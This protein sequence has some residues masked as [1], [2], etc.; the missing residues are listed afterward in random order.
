MNWP[1]L[2]GAISGALIAGVA[3]LI[4]SYSDELTK[5]AKDTWGAIGDGW[6]DVTGEAKALID[7]TVAAAEAAYTWIADGIS[8]IDPD[9]IIDSIGEGFV[10]AEKSVESGI[11]EFA[12]S[13]TDKI[14]DALGIQ[15]SFEDTI[16][17]A[18]SS[19]PGMDKIESS[20]TTPATSPGEPAPG[21]PVKVEPPAGKGAVDALMPSPIPS[22]DIQKPTATG[23]P[24]ATP[25]TSSPVK[26]GE[27]VKTTPTPQPRQ[28]DVAR[29]K[30]T[31]RGIEG[32]E[33]AKQMIKDHEGKRNR[34]YKD[35][36]GLWTVG[37]G[38]LIGDGKSL[39]A[40]MNREFSDEEVNAMFEE[41][42]AHHAKAARSIAG[43]DKLNPGGQAALE[44]LTF[45]MGPTWYKKWPKF[46]AALASG[47]TTGAADQLR[48]SKW[49]GQVGG[50]AVQIAALIENGSTGQPVA[51]ASGVKGG[52]D[53]EASSSGGSTASGLA[54]AGASQSAIGA[55]GGVQ[56][57]SIDNSKTSVNG[58]S[59]GGD[60]NSPSR[61]NMSARN[62]DPSIARANAYAINAT[63]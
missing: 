47:D 62:P 58:T 46:S 5:M 41:D 10:E 63:A 55:G 36:L 59:S 60:K 26:P 38:H 53:G 33:G 14:K 17:D 11:S 48:N 19:V 52:I 18:I 44:D 3:A 40:N 9:K 23:T 21:E 39:P 27:P 51:S 24:A 34:P 56:V 15:K 32:P 61:I 8:N 43:Y 12:T 1:I 6:D 30:A 35:S 13:V 57:A 22:G 20:S 42:Y 16:N 4:S 29:K 31:V 37:Y 7:D 28:S 25:Q 49:Y 54:V 45:N 2:I 50:R